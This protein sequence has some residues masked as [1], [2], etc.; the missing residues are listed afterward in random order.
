MQGRHSALRIAIDDSTRATLQGWLRRQ[1]TPVGLAK[2]ARAMLLLA[3]GQ[4]FAATA[5][6]VELRERHVRKWALRFPVRTPFLSRLSASFVWLISAW[7]R[8]RR[9]VR[10]C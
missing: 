10:P 2:R 1:K 5:R 6:H 8:D 4:T 9:A 7:M 3:D